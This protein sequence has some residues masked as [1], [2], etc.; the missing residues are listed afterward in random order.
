MSRLDCTHPL[1]AILNRRPAGPSRLMQVEHLDLR[2]TNGEERTFERI[3]A[4]GRGAVIV[5]PL[6]DP[7]TV[8][9][10]REYAAGLHRYE[11][12][13]PKGRLEAGETPQQGAN[14]E[15]Q[16]EIGYAARRLVSLGYLTLAPGYMAHRTELIVASDLYPSRLEG[17][18]PE[19]LETLHW[20]LDDLQRLVQCEACS[21]GRSIAAL[22]M[23]RE[24]VQRF[25]DPL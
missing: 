6:L 2:F 23:A 16:E 13:L 14:R 8:I 3:V 19:P 18:E 10:V 7:N 11:L 15:L 25:F 12:G 4:R 24:V 21:E 5:V 22:F 20:R 9:L 1:P 17:D